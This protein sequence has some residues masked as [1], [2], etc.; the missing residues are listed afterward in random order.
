MPNFFAAPRIRALIFARFSLEYFDAL[1]AWLMYD[2][3]ALQCAAVSIGYRLT[4]SFW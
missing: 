2:H 3:A 4:P 1:L